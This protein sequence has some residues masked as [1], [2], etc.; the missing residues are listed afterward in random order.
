MARFLLLR[1]PAGRAGH[2]SA[3]AGCALFR[4]PGGRQTWAY[5]YGEARA[6]ADPL[7]RLH[8]YG[9]AVAGRRGVGAVPENL[10]ADI[11]LLMSRS[12]MRSWVGV[13]ELLLD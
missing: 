8:L 7:G 9:L 10:L 1:G 5:I 13:D 4:R 11:D 12:D 2:L 6:G 3:A